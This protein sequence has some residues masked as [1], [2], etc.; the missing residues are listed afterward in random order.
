MNVTLSNDIPSD[1][2]K[3]IRA[4]FSAVFPDISVKNAAHQTGSLF[5]ELEFVLG[6]SDQGH[7][8]LWQI[9]QI[10][11]DR[12]VTARLIAQVTVAAN[13]VIPRSYYEPHVIATAIQCD[14]KEFTRCHIEKNEL[15][16]I[17]RHLVEKQQLTYDLQST[18]DANTQF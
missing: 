6:A 16:S 17:V 3:Q 13:T 14:S 10:E 15:D 9:T 4:Y 1:K 2:A 12:V 18:L 5:G 7:T 11:T 8:T